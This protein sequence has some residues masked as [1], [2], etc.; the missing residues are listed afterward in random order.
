M[1]KFGI[2]VFSPLLHV[3]SRRFGRP[4]IAGRKPVVLRRRTE[5]SFA[6]GS[7]SNELLPPVNHTSA[8]CQSL[9]DGAAI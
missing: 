5:F 7:M 3:A 8:S 2:A 4:R 9:L 6:H 1:R